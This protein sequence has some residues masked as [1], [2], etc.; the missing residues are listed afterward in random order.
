MQQTAELDPRI[1]R[2]GIEVNGQF[3]I[4]DGLSIT[5]TGTKY[6]NPNQ[7]ECEVKIANLDQQTR[8][9]ILTETS[10]FNNNKTRK[11]LTIDAGRRSTGVSRVFI[12]NISKVF[13][14]Q[15]PDITLTLKC[16]T[17]NYQKGNLVS[18]TG[19]SNQSLKNISQGVANDLGVTLNFQASDKQISN[20]NYS[21]GALNQ[22]NKLD[23]TGNVNAYID[24]D[25]LVVKDANIPLVNTL[26]VVNLESG[27]IGIP[28][29]TEQGIKVKFLFDNKTVL[30]GRLRVQSKLYPSVNGDY[31]IFKLGF[32][33]SSRDVPFYWIAEGKRL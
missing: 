27:M 22:V 11:I 28:E 19:R 17:L 23:E 10:P 6:A 4:Y 24:D 30:G 15:P 12:G 5:A 8:Q 26:K 20:Y 16:L 3:K 29:V 21:G 33:I 25:V 31:V 1:I 9:F 18:R 7:N 14:S 13:P 32:E 2:V